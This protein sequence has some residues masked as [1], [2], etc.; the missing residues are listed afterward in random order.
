MNNAEE[1]DIEKIQTKYNL[2]IDE[3]FKCYSKEIKSIDNSRR[4]LKKGNEI[5]NI[6]K[7]SKKFDDVIDNIPYF[8]NLEFDTVS[9][10]KATGKS[11]EEYI[12]KK[13]DKRENIQVEKNNL[14]LEII[15][16]E[17][18]LK[19]MKYVKLKKIESAIE[20]LEKNLKICKNQLNNILNSE[21]ES[22]EKKTVEYLEYDDSDDD[23]DDDEKKEFDRKKINENKKTIDIMKKIKECHKLIP[24]GI[25]FLYEETKKDFN[26]FGNIISKPEENLIGNFIL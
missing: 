15:E 13:N 11:K 5:W 26:A 7:N 9:K 3:L 12:G 25:T 8:F 16:L 23:S 19:D 18:K 6:I 14:K 22:K 17:E 24:E 20:N 21:G 10:S 1:E 2:F 4:I